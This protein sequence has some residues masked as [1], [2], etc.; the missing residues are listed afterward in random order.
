MGRNVTIFKTR[1]SAECR[2]LIREISD[3]PEA[4]ND[5]FP[6]MSGTPGQHS[7]FPFA[8]LIPGP[9][10]TLKHWWCGA[11]QANHHSPKLLVGHR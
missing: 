9:L 6:G 11:L 2:Q 5:L 10:P 1:A 8:F 4:I 7:T 3:R